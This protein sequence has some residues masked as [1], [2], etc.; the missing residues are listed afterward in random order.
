MRPAPL[1]PGR[2][3]SRSGISTG[4]SCRSQVRQAAALALRSDLP[5]EDPAAIR[6]LGQSGAGFPFLRDGY[7]VTDSEPGPRDRCCGI[8]WW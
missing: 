7:C 2:A 1:V 8:S 6:R 5:R 4:P 3:V